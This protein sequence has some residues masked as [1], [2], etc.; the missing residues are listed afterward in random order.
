MVRNSFVLY[1]IDR[2]A[3]LT[4]SFYIIVWTH[5]AEPSPRSSSLANPPFLEV[6]KSEYG[7]ILVLLESSTDDD[8]CWNA[9]KMVNQTESY[10]LFYNAISLCSFFGACLQSKRSRGWDLQPRENH[11]QCT[12]RN[13][14]GVGQ[15]IVFLD[16]G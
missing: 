15:K 12:A 16:R 6:M 14:D 10:R 2:H 9:E 5:P 7:D 1:F 8:G 4:S 11:L 13:M 3:L